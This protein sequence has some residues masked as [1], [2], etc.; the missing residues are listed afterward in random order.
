LWADSFRPGWGPIA[1]FCEYFTLWSS[2]NGEKF[3]WRS[4]RLL[5]WLLRG[6]LIS[7]LMSY[8][9]P[10]TLIFESSC[11]RTNIYANCV[12]SVWMLYSIFWAFWIPFLP[13]TSYNA[14]KWFSTSDVPTTPLGHC[15]S[16]S[17]PTT[18]WITTQWISNAWTFL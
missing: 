14:S 7:S 6:I 10:R 18:I 16:Y 13:W 15:L 12:A 5:V 4:E 3:F 1:D 11:V 9:L 2:I 8:R 17:G